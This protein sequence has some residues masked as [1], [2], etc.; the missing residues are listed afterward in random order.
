M[1]DRNV[2]NLVQQ[3]LAMEG[4]SW[5]EVLLVEVEV[6]MEIDGQAMT[7]PLTQTWSWVPG[8][9]ISVDSLMNED[10]DARF[11][12]DQ[13]LVSVQQLMDEDAAERFN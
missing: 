10:A 4:L 6:E 12:G 7:F 8:D 3:Y 2:S 13:Y 5:D 9:G 1:I 11:D